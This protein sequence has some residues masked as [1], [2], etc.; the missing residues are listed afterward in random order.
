MTRGLDRRSAGLC[1][2]I[3]VVLIALLLSGP[4]V[5]AIGMAVAIVASLPAHRIARTYRSTRTSAPRTRSEPM[6]LGFAALGWALVAAVGLFAPARSVI[7]AARALQR[8]HGSATIAT[9]TEH[10]VLPWPMVIDVLVGGALVCSLLAARSLRRA[11][12]IDDS[13]SSRS[14]MRAR[15]IVAEHGE[16]SLAPF[17]LRPDKSFEFA[18]D[19]VVA[20]RVVGDTVVV[21]GDPVGPDVAAAAAFRGLLQRARRAGLRTTVYGASERHLETYRAAGLRLLQVGEEAIVGPATFTLEGRRV[22]KLRQSVHRV[23]RRGWRIE[24]RDGRDIE[25]ELEAEIDGVETAWRDRRDRLLGFAMSMGEFEPGVG[26]DDVYALAWSPDGRLQAVMRFISHRRNL[27]LDTMRRI[28]ETPN[29]LNEA[30]V[31]HAVDFA[32]AR[33]VCE[34]SLNYAGLGHLVRER[35]S[36]GWLSRGLTAMLIKVLKGRFQMD[37]LVLFNEKFLPLWRPRYLIYESRAGLPRSVLR[38]L[39][40]EGYVPEGTTRRAGRD[41]EAPFWPPSTPLEEGLIG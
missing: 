36:L 24:V 25:R 20:Y 23:Q 17:I 8:T 5:T 33:G 27:S 19:G 21:S 34:V 39:Q 26:P 7:H 41:A 6:V 11:A 18:G 2:G 22:R 9:A 10:L 37:R 13:R 1:L 28:G 29:G 16:D 30:L 38:V 3:A 35:H 4:K 15:S 31:C 32:R 40:A 14:L 12:M